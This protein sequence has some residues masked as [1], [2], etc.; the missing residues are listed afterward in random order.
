MSA[1]PVYDISNPD[2]R[3]R[4]VRD[5]ITPYRRDCLA[6]FFHARYGDPLPTTDP[7]KKGDRHEPVRHKPEL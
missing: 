5:E 7:T 3:S 6:E 4:M 1:V 2:D